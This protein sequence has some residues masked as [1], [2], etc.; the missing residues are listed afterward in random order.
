MLA[1][2]PH[3]TEFEGGN[4][5]SDFRIQPI[6]KRLQAIHPDVNA[7]RARFVHLVAIH[8]VLRASPQIPIR[9]RWSS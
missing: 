3:I 5:L 9:A 1:V 4:A 8:L 7:L 6:L 2:T